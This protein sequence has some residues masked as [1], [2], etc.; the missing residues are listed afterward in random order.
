MVGKSLYRLLR[1]PTCTSRSVAVLEG[2]VL[3][4]TCK[5][6]YPIHEGYID[7]MPREMAFNYIS[8]YVAE[9]EHMGEE[10][11]YR[12]MA[13]PL[14]AA[15]V[16]HRQIRRM[17][18]FKPSDVV[19]DNAC[20]NGRFGLWNINDVDTMIGSDPAV[21]FADQALEELMLAQADSRR[22][23]FDDNVF[24]KAISVDVLEHFPRDVMHD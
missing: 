20:G 1:C 21:L 17:L 3:C 8:K 12:A 7:L 9:E 6:E 24:D 15:G 13:P 4:G 23:P 22:L 14:L 18:D 19:F 10:L 5:T 11:D 2:H 16:R